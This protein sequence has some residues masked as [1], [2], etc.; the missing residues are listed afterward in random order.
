MLPTDSVIV[1]SMKLPIVIERLGNN[2]FKVRPVRSVLYNTLF[3]LKS[4]SHMI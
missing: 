2:K 3:K 1:A 4:K